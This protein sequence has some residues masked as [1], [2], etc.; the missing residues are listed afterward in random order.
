VVSR[1]S[2]KD[3]VDGRV[4][5]AA[6]TSCHDTEDVVLCWALGRCNLIGVRGVALWEE[7]KRSEG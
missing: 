7:R 5:G 4:A 6:R 3:E 1:D 2:A